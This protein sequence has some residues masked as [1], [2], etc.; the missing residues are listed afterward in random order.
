MEDLLDDTGRIAD[1]YRNFIHVSRYARWR[2]ED[3]RRET[4]TE[5][6]DRYIEFMLDHLQSN[7]GYTP[8]RGETSLVRDFILS[9]EGLPSMR[10]LMT[11]GPAL[12]RNNIAGYNCCYLVIDDPVALDELLYILMNGTGVGFSVE[13]KY[14][15][16]LPSIPE[17]FEK[18]GNVVVE[19]SKEGWAYG[20]RAVL[21]FLWEGRLPDW[22]VTG[23]RR[24]GERLKTFGGRASGPEPLVDLFVYA[25]KLFYHARG[26]QLTPLEVH[27]LVCKIASVVVVGGVRRSALISLGDLDS[28]EMRGAKDGEWWQ[29]ADHRTLANNSAVYENKPSREK[30]DREWSALVASGSGE[31]GIFNRE[32]SR[33]QAGL[34]G[35]RNTNFDFGTNPC[36]EIILRPYQ[37]CNLSTIVVDPED[38]YDTL[39]NKVAAATILGTWQSTLTNFKYIR[40]IYRHNTEEERLLG[41]SMTG[42]LG[43]TL[44]NFGQGKQVTESVLLSLKNLAVEVNF[45]VA[46][47]IGIP[48]SAAVTCIKP[49]GTT[50]QLTLTSSGLHPWHSEYYIRT[51]RGDKKDPLTEFMVDAGFPYEDERF[52]PEH[53]AVFAFPIKAPEGAITRH[54][55]TALEHLDIWL[56][57][58]KFWCEHKPSVTINVAPDE[59]EEV[60]NWVFDNFDDLSGVAFLPK[61][62]HVYE[63]APYQDVTKEEYDLLV[64]EMPREVDWSMLSAYELEDSTTSTQALACVAGACEVIDITS[65]TPAAMAV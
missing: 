11:A 45:Q 1:P 32:A 63:Q 22:D 20:L 48:R 64:S 15:S 46:E 49:E 47:D 2:E 37:F 40:D 43:N 12:A 19:D 13:E 28:D 60:G 31:R 50:S 51:V 33:R 52:N 27:D 62:E 38:T 6:V 4:W 65:P 5:T 53:T 29:F 61:T 58:Q 10:A 55:M 25:S 26:R 30:F 44:L 39:K 17:H 18:G 35:R 56:T 16:K 24:A 54:E 9:Q 36:S 41:V 21:G 3:G 14:V 42:P 8:S 23:V 59:W 7:N 34:S 57:Y